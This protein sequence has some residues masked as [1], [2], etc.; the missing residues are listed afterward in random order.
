ML[1]AIR[2]FS[3]SIFA[4]ILLGI[5]VIPFVF[6]GMG[7]SFTGGNKNVIVIIDKEKYTNKEFVNYIQK[8]TATEQKITANQIEEFLSMFIGDK[9]VKKEA[10]RLGIELTDNSLSKLIKHQKDFK[11]ENV[12]SRTEYEKF[13]LKNNIDA[14]SFEASIAEQEK[15]KQ[16]LNFIG[17][18]ILPSDFLINSSYNEINQKRNI[19][20]IDLNGLFQKQIIFSE[21]E[22]RSYYKKNKNE[23]NEIY[24]SVKILELSP[25]NLIGNNEFNDLFFKKIDEIDDLIIQGEDFEYISLKFNLENANE[26]TINKL[27]KDLNS[28]KINEI[29]ENLIANIFL[30][31]QTESTVLI[32]NNDKYFIAKL[33]KIKNIDKGPENAETKKKIMEKLKIQK[34]REI[35]VDIISKINNNKFSKFDF[36]DLSK[37]N[38]LNV[39]KIKLNHQNDDQI[40]EKNLVSEIYRFAEKR[41]IVI[42]D[43]SLEQSFLVYIDK[44]EN[45]NINEK[46]EEY[47]KHLNLSKIK[48]SNNLFN[49]YDR[50][51]KKKYNIDINYKSLD[52]VENYFN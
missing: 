16:L 47:K 30:I 27:G 18:G 31:D 3:G 21:K 32:E 35:L 7:S 42:N 4:K 43:I 37:K 15:K 1:S 50:Y 25:K 22:I 51:I 11:R 17:G 36:D 23:Y 19:E 28:K 26:F 20:I 8:F 38:N 24:R 9:L 13:L 34:K 10:E 45:V 44:I 2:K 14:A 33:L 29:S 49:S 48:I 5:I 46:P 39:R 12:F 41:I 6:W 40:L 52:I